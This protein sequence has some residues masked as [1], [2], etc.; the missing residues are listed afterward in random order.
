MKFVILEVFIHN[1]SKPSMINVQ[2]CLKELAGVSIKPQ[3]SRH[4][5]FCR[6]CRFSSTYY[7]NMISI[8]TRD[9]LCIHFILAECQTSKAHRGLIFHPLV[10]KVDLTL[11]LW[12]Q[13][14]VC[15]FLLLLSTYAFSVW[16]LRQ[17]ELYKTWTWAC[18]SWLPS[19]FCVTEKR[20]EDN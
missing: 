2:A 19:L 12:C 18:S 16:L 8:Q 11:G 15:F 20:S 5:A 14:L 13:G 4:H 1:L 3:A 10:N 6:P 7:R 17:R 9:K